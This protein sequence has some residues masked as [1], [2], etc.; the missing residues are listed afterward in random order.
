MVSKIESAGMVARGEVAEIFSHETL[1]HF[2]VTRARLLIQTFPQ[3]FP[4]KT[5]RFAESRMVDGIET[6]VWEYLFR[7]R[8]ICKDRVASLTAE[9]L[10]DP[11]I[12]VEVPEG[13]NGNEAKSHLMIDGIHRVFR[14]KQLGKPEYYLYLLPM[15]V[16]PMVPDWAVR[17]SDELRPDLAWGKFDF[18]NGVFVDRETGQ[19]VG[20]IPGVW[21]HG[22]R[23][24]SA[25]GG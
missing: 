20:D 4:R 3:L 19:K 6:D 25:K 1:G 13:M 9:E 23:V 18:V 14:R 2:D 12:F 15:A 22:R 17:L 16:V 24:D 7:A 8:D 5:A 10:I 11:A 21:E